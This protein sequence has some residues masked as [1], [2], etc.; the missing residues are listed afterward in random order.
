M[1]DNA[2]ARAKRV[3]VKGYGAIG[4]RHARLLAEAGHQPIVATGQALTE[5]STYRDLTGAFGE[6][7]RIDLVIIASVT[8]QHSDD[9]R[10]LRQLGYTG[11]VLVEKPL[12]DQMPSPAERASP[13]FHVMV[14][15]N[16]RFHPIIAA[17]QQALEGRKLLSASLVA[18]QNLNQWRPGRRVSETYSAHRHQGGGV[19]RDLSHE[20]DLAQ[21]LFGKLQLV[22]SHSSRVGEITV[23]S[24]D[25]A[26]AVFTTQACPFISVQLDYLDSSPRR[27]IRIVTDA[28][29]I[30][31]D[32][33]AS[34][35]TIDG[36]VEAIPCPADSS[37]RHMHAAVLGDRARV[38]N[39]DEGLEI[40]E[41]ADRIAPYV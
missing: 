7:G 5:Y 38:C 33:I 15:Y 16:L 28:S 39:W 20:L 10:V 29:T 32:L 1:F 14:A 24:E 12:F 21:Y 31:A 17:L 22:A 8:A 23:D 27:Q 13:P 26:L 35:L 37:Y 18:G 4:R 25:V 34:T 6:Q 19:V 11:S 3:I 30:V 2:E 41:L 9:L 40:V 36:R